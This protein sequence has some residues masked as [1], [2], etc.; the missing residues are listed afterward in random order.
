MLWTGAVIEGDR[1][2]SDPASGFPFAWTGARG[3]FGVLTLPRVLTLGNVTLD[4]GS[5]DYFLKT[6]PLPQLSK[7]RQPRSGA[8][9]GSAVKEAGR[10]ATA[11][12]HGPRE[13]SNE[14]WLRVLH[15]FRDD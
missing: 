13:R 14:G 15:I 12:H 2:P 11:D 10:G 1:D 8:G 4:D 6:A 3:W 7:L 5:F 9:V